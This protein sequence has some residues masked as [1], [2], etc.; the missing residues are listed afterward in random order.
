VITVGYK[1]TELQTCYWRQRSARASLPNCFQT[2]S[3]VRLE[4][5][6]PSWSI[7]SY[8]EPSRKWD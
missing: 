3:M 7:P 1:V 2:N 6:V 8:P 5:G 4:Q